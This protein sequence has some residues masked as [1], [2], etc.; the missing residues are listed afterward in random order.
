MK[1]NIFTSSYVFKVYHIIAYIWERF[2]SRNVFENKK[3]R[4]VDHFDG[5]G[6]D[7]DGLIILI[8]TA[9]TISLLCVSK[10][11]NRVHSKDREMN[12]NVG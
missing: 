5:L 11:R 4:G 7:S 9:L 6:L 1:I 2:Y 12:L 3:I 8:A 10:N